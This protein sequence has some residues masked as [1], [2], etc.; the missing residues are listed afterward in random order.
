MANLTETAAPVPPQNW[1]PEAYDSDGNLLPGYELDENGYPVY[2]GAPTATV[3]DPGPVANNNDDGIPEITVTATRLP[4]DAEDPFE[5]ARQAREADY[6]INF[7]QDE[8]AVLAANEAATRERARQQ[9]VLSARRSQGNNGDW[10]FKLQLSPNADY[11][12][13]TDTYGLLD[14][15]KNKGVIF[16]YTPQIEMN[17]VAN[18]EKYDLVHSNYRGY[19]YRNSNLNEISVRA[20]F[21]AQDTY[22]AQYLLAVIHFFRS[23]TKMFYGKDTQ[24]GAPPPLV[25]ASGFGPNQFNFHACLVSSFTYS[26]PNDVDYIRADSPNQIGVNL[27][28]R[29]NRS[30][31]LGAGGPLTSIIN[32]LKNANLFS[33]ALPQLPN[34]SQV[35]QTVYNTN[36]S[37][38]TYVPTK[39]ELALTLL[40]VQTRSEVSQQFSLQGFANGQLLKGGFW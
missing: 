4:A 26:L 38:A 13:Q 11:L 39:I 28:N 23:V 33:G 22:E 9:Q 8:S 18:Y 17:Y 15:L 40:P 12:Y 21:T 27:E 5:A 29:A 34:P 2:V 19:F 20:P 24:A 32:R 25:Y 6:D 3:F 37:N 31:A 36:A 10:R 7:G 14:P 35:R 1:N 16:P 30:S